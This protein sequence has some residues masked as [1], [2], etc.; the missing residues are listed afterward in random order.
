MITLFV[1]FATTS[2]IREFDIKCVMNK[3][4]KGQT[5]AELLANHPTLP[6]DKSEQHIANVTPTDQMLPWTLCFDGAAMGQRGGAGP[7]G[8]ASDVL[9]EP[10]SKLHLHTYGSSYFCTNNSTT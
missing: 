2:T 1:S 6:Q 3:A 4:I 5:L 10:S 8:G 7:C 9:M